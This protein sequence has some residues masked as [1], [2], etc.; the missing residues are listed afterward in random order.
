[1]TTIAGPPA[2]DEEDIGDEFDDDS[3]EDDYETMEE[4]EGD[5]PPS[6]GH[7]SNNVKDDDKENEDYGEESDSDLELL[8]AIPKS[9]Q[10]SSSLTPIKQ[11]R[12]INR[13]SSPKI[14]LATPNKSRLDESQNLSCASC[15][16]LTNY[17]VDMGIKE[18]NFEV[19]N[20]Q[21]T[22]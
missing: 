20:I 19:I 21:T 11:N 15:G 13:I 3:S 1:M 16:D 9:L 6:E 12:S 5:F 14:S 8:L 17:S 7:E 10:L 18:T 22:P 2:Q 4:S